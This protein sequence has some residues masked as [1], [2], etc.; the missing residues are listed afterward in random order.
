[1]TEPF[2]ELETAEP[3]QRER[4]LFAALVEQLA[5][6]RENAPGYA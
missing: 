2:D 5:H 3:E 4:R 1:M 6:A